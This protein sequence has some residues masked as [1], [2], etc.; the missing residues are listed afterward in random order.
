MEHSDTV[1]GDIET[2]TNIVLD[3]LDEDPNYYS[4]LKAIE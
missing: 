2:V 4:K 3:H 1:G